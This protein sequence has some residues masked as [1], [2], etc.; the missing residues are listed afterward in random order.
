MVFCVRGD[1]LVMNKRS[2][3]SSGCRIGFNV[4]VLLQYFISYHVNFWLSR[5][6]WAG[7]PCTSLSLPFFVL[8]HS[9]LADDY[10]PK[11]F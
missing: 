10:G 3:R 6:M 2:G 8:N 11:P 5:Y 7:I 4:V 9:M 1:G